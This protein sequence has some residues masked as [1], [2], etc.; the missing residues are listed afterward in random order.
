MNR[1][2]ILKLVIFSDLHY[3]DEQHEEQ[4]NRKLTK[5]AISL[6]EN[7]EEKIN[8]NINQIYVFI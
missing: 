8:N 1:Q 3:L 5:L 2:K 6:L 7:L 4:Y